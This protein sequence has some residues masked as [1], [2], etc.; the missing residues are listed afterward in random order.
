V[1]R[2]AVPFVVLVLACGCGSS[3]GLST[4][5]SSLSVSGPNGDSP[6]AINVGTRVTLRIVVKDAAGD[7]VTPT[8]PLSFA[9]RNTTVATVDSAGVVSAISLGPTYIVVTLAFD[10][11]TL[12]DSVAVDVAAPVA[13]D[14]P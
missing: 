1:V 6:V 10:S 11:R 5:P 2:H 7:V 12:E 4:E 14:H 8:Q 3:T 9:S 13:G